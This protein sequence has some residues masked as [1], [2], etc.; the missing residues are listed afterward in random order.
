MSK[1]STEATKANYTDISDKPAEA[2]EA[3]ADKANE[4]TNEADVPNQPG[5]ADVA[6]KPGK[7]E[8]N[9]AEADNAI[10]IDEAEFANK[11]DL[12]D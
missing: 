9:K 10:V 11:A 8:A 4:A 6:D 5:K 1:P 3:E 2:D 12:A 7:A